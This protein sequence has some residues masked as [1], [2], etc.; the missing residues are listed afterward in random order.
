MQFFNCILVN[1][2]SRLKEF[3][4]FIDNSDSRGQLIKAKWV[5]VVISASPV[6]TFASEF[7]NPL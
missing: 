5:R 1:L 2:G 3:W 6:Q 4:S 7:E